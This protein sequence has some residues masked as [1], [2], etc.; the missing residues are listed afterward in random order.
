MNEE[1][2]TR[3]RDPLSV[4]DIAARSDISRPFDSYHVEDDCTKPRTEM[5]ITRAWSD[6][7]WSFQRSID[8]DP[9]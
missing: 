4:S 8:N 5:F 7:L 3:T 1:I 2:I 9:R 6:E